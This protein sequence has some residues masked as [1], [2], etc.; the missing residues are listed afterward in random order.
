MLTAV[1]THVPTQVL[2]D[3][4]AQTDQEGHVGDVATESRCEAAG[5]G[6]L[7]AEAVRVSLHLRKGIAVRDVAIHGDN[8]AVHAIVRRKVADQQ[9]CTTVSTVYRAAVGGVTEE[10]TTVDLFTVVVGVAVK[11][12]SVAQVDAKVGPQL[13][14]VTDDG[15]T[16]DH[17]GYRHILIAIVDQ[18]LCIGALLRTAGGVR[19]AP[20]GGQVQEARIAQRQTNVACDG[21]L[22]AVTFVV[23]TVAHFN[24]ATLAGVVQH[25]VHYAR[26]GVRTV[27]G[28]G[29]VAQDFDTLQ[30][31]RG[32][33]GRV[34]AL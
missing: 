3:F 5:N 31:Q 34:R 7:E 24:G 27:L 21:D 16:P 10:E 14:V 12:Q 13:H 18:A 11:L 32:D 2:A 19:L 30:R 8:R 33:G 9:R 22:L 6:F 4:A 17:G 1:S 26:D 20:L 25:K 23:L 29:A 28:R 15:T